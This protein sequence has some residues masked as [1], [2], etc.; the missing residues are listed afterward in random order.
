MIPGLRDVIDDEDADLVG[1][2]ALQVIGVDW[3]DT[4]A[5]GSRIAAGVG[6]GWV[7]A[8]RLPGVRQPAAWATG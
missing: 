8:R 4:L 7:V 5:A 3:M 6:P 2:L 1:H